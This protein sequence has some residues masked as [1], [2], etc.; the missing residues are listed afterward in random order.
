VDP[1]E[2]VVGILMAQTDTTTV[3]PELETT[4]MQAI[5]EPAGLG[6]RNPSD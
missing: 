5:V 6:R 1:K 3:R 4:V 2:H